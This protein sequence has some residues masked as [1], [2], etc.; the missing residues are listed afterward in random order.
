M[1]YAHTVTVTTSRRPIDG[2]SSWQIV[3]TETECAATSEWDVAPGD[4]GG[5]PLPATG[6]I[7]AYDAVKTGTAATLQPILSG[8]T[9]P[10]STQSNYIGAQ[11]AA[12]ASVHD[13]SST[14]YQGLTTLY[15]RSRPDAGAD[16]AI[17]TTITIVEGHI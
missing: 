1:A 4:C 17:T 14:R 11:V 3:V 6:T 8:T 5:Y 13:R 15:G 12:A 16:N 7:T 9:A 2:R 10:A